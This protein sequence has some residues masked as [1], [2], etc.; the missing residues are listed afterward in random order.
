MERKG[1]SMQSSVLM[2]LIAVGVSSCA[3]PSKA[4]QEKAVQDALSA[5]IQRE[6]DKA[7]A[8]ADSA[9]QGNA[10]STSSFEKLAPLSAGPEFSAATLVSQVHALSHA[11]HKYSDAEYEHVEAVLGVALPADATGERRGITGKF[12]TGTYSWVVWKQSRFPVGRSVELSLDPP[13]LCL[14]FEALKAPLL[15]DGFTMY[16]PTFGDDDRITFHKRVESSLTLYVA[17]SVDRRDSPA[18]GRKVTL[19]LGPSDD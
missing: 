2:A 19:D 7:A 14:A 1:I 18:C 15:A 4:N 8:I 3:Q 16:V 11:L 17:I 9:I 12:G 10:Q 5:E 13:S 6:Q